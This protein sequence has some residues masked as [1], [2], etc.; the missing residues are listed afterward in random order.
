MAFV[1]FQSRLPAFWD[2]IR[3]GLSPAD[4]GVAV[5]VSAGCGQRWFREAGGVKP[6][7]PVVK[8]RGV[9][10]RLTLDERIE[11]QAGVH[12]GES[13]R[14]M[15]RR[16]GRAPSTI[17]REI[18]TNGQRRNRGRAPTSGYRRKHAFGACQSGRTA[19]VHYQATAAHDRCAVHAQRPK[20]RRLATE[21]RLR[22]G[23]QLHVWRGPGARS[24]I[25][26]HR[27]PCSPR[28]GSQR[29][30]IRG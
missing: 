30:L 1:R 2:L 25:F 11:I 28:H 26:G 20:P 22:A 19:V 23:R 4:A 29:G 8:S 12:A 3:R 24:A 5:G 27:G 7:K 6:A 10:R 21:L 13:L 17:K 18:D 16:L 14:S 9:R 15:A